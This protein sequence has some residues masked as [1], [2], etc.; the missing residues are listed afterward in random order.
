MIHLVILVAL[1]VGQTPDDHGEIALPVPTYQG[2][3]A[4]APIPKELHFRN[5][6]GSDGS[7]LCVIAS[8]VINGAYQRIPGL[9]L[10]KDSP[11]WKAAKQKPGGY[12][13][14][15]LDDLITEVMPTEEWVGYSDRDPAKLDTILHT[16]SA[17]GRAIGAT[18]N[19]GALYKYAPIHHMISLVHYESG[20]LACVVDNND[21]GLYHWMPASEF[22]KRLMDGGEGWAFAWSRMPLVVKIG[23]SILVAAAALL[24]LASAALVSAAA[25][26]L[27]TPE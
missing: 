2:T 24:L 20:K 10:L 1:V 21:P 19:T 7:G 5:E 18:M 9:T 27:L 4:N 11:L 15:K 8:V 13:P 14:K 25:A 17:S 22:L 12:Y 3:T 6:G 26:I 16:L 23:I